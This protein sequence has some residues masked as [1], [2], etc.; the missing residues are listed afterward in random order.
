MS[1]APVVD[2]RPM[3][4]RERHPRIF[5]TF[6]DLAPGAMMIL[7][8][9]H[10]PKPLWYQFQMEMPGQFTWTYVEEGPEVWK[11]EIRKA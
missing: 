4:P 8:N 6:R 10:D 7:V 11:V 1:E 5:Q 2:V 3:P 9:D